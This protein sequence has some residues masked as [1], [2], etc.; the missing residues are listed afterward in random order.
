MRDLAREPLPAEMRLQ[1]WSEVLSGERD[2][3]AAGN[4]VAAALRDAAV[5]FN[6]PIAPFMELID[7]H[8]FGV[9]DE[10][11]RSLEALDSYAAKTSGTIFHMAEW[12]LQEGAERERSRCAIEA[13]QAEAIAFILANL[14]RHAARHQLYVPMELLR[15]HRVQ[16][17]SIWELRSTSELR[18]ALAELRVRAVRHLSELASRG[19]SANQAIWPAFL[20][21]APL[22]PW[23]RSQEGADY[24]LF[25]P[26][27][28][29]PFWRQW[30]IWQA[31]RAFGRIDR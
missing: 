10:P 4:P 6:M 1:W 2:A 15:R 5:R 9:Y 24:D 14:G 21:L 26:P 20:S 17:N 16:V 19:A 23:L 31:A 18:S 11:M 28:M 29:S 8:R 25:R 22:R 12:I 3:D 30:R 7:A 13:G 27:E